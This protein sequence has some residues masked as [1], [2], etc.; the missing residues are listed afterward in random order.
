[1]LRLT[2]L[3]VVHCLLLDS[4]QCL[5]QLLSCDRTWLKLSVGDDSNED[6]ELVLAHVYLVVLQQLVHRLWADFVPVSGRVKDSLETSDQEVNEIVRVLVS[7]HISHHI[8]IP[9]YTTRGERIACIRL[10]ISDAF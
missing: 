1:M 2:E 10:K 9:L 8:Q 7:R 4:Y 6:L 3:I 5:L